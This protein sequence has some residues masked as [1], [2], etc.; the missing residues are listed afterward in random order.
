MEGWG[1]IILRILNGELTSDGER[2]YLLVCDLVALV[3]DPI[4]PLIANNIRPIAKPEVFYKAAGLYALELV[5][6]HV[7]KHFDPIQLGVSGRRG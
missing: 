3:K 7:Q 5:I 6:S 1:R 2:D 4:S